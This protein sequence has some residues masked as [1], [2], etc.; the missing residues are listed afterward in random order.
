MLGIVLESCIWWRFKM[1]TIHHSVWKSKKSHFT[2]LRAERVINGKFSEFWQKSAVELGELFD[3]FSNNLLHCHQ[4]IYILR[5]DNTKVLL[6][7]I[8]GVKQTM[9]Q[10]RAEQRNWN[11]R[12]SCNSLSDC[13]MSPAETKETVQIKNQRKIP[14]S[15]VNHS[16]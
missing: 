16:C 11:W 10:Y 14:S 3:W 1:K 8:Y 7:D 13:G 6:L 4:L 12:A 15:L 5:W 2:T 9:R